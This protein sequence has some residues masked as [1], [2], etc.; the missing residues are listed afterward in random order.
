MDGNACVKENKLLIY[1]TANNWVTLTWEAVSPCSNKHQDW[2]LLLKALHLAVHNLLGETTDQSV[3]MIMGFRGLFIMISVNRFQMWEATLLHATY[4]YFT[5]NC[6]H[7][8][9]TTTTVKVCFFKPK[10][11]PQCFFHQVDFSKQLLEKKLFIQQLAHLWSQFFTEN[12]CF[13]E[14]DWIYFA[15]ITSLPQSK[16][17]LLHI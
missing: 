4:V 1:L 12:N 2:H 15:A 11:N 7:Q 6:R 3:A 9:T 10:I 16:V 17:D 13:H 5:G 8:P 14:T